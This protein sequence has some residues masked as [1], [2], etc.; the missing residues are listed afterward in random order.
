MDFYSPVTLEELRD[1]SDEEV[2][3]R[4][5]DNIAPDE[6]DQTIFSF[7]AHFSAQFYMA[8]LDRRENRRAE[9]E[10]D[11]T[12]KKRWNIDF[13]L[14]TLIVVLILIEIGL[15]IWDHRQYSKDATAELNTFSGMQG[16]LSNLQDTSKA[17]AGTMTALEGTTQAMNTAL[18]KQLALFY[19][20]A[21]NVVIDREKKRISIANT[22][23]TNVAFWGFKVGD[24]APEMRKEGSE[25]PPGA[26]INLEEFAIYDLMATQFPSPKLGTIQFEVFLKNERGEE[27]IQQANIW[28]SW[29]NNVEQVAAETTL[30]EPEHWS[31]NQKDRATTPN[32]PSTA[33]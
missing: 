11:R 31:R 26:G 17:T 1:L 28:V 32:A 4:I 5:N 8:E 9:A 18:Q 12:E 30:T 20:V 33:P 25:I 7:P 24:Q 15:S 3:K 21:L 29:P 16:A 19:D 27:F 14:E 6:D 23:R 10:R 2:V 22:G 13:M